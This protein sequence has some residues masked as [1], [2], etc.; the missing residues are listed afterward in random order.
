MTGLLLAYAEQSSR[1]VNN[2]SNSLLQA[3]K[4]AFF[5]CRPAGDPQAI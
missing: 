5:I 2:N 4:H 3:K 1:Y